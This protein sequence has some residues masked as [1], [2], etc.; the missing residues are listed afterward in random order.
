MKRILHIAE[1]F[2]GGIITFIA[3]L[4]NEQCVE[5][6]VIIAHGIRPETHSNY[7]DFFDSRIK[8]LRVNNF[9]QEIGFI[10][11]TRAVLELRA[12]IAK[13]GPDVIHMHSSQSGVLGKLAS[14]NTKS[15]KVYSPHGFSFLKQDVSD[16]KR[17]AFKS[18]EKVFSL[19]DC[20]LVASS[21]SEFAEA[22]L[23]TKKSVL[24][25]NGINTESLS[26]FLNIPKNNSKI[27][28]GMIGRALPQ[29]NPRLFNSIASRMPD[30]DFVWIGDGELRNEL[31]APNI[32]I[33][34][35][36]SR[37]EAL[38]YL[39]KLDIYIMTSLWEGMPLSLLEAMYL[40]I[41]SVVTN[42]V[43]NRDVIIDN[44]N[45]YVVNNEDEFVDKIKF[46]AN[47]TLERVRM[48]NAAYCDICEKFNS[49]VM[50]EN[51]N[52]VYGF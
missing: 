4:A 16:L 24:I 47:N 43:G 13:I 21:S 51:F 49:K 52:K 33:V 31:K 18:I 5:H 9:R 44:F 38:H 12:L 10:Q 11:E 25:N 3:N 42:V 19:F 14:L 17:F 20:T 50:A 15:V 2:G 32:F 45:G 41:P 46:L 40:K 8:L 23:I 27:T 48:G 7:V 36:G 30:I 28:V 39:A 34:G 22:K 26:K 35:W 29:K 6:E 37:E 1:A